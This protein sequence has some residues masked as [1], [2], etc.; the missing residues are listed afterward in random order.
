MITHERHHLKEPCPR[1]HDTGR[2]ECQCIIKG[3][4]G[5]FTCCNTGKLD[6]DCQGEFYC[7]DHDTDHKGECGP[8]LGEAADAARD[9]M[10]CRV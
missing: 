1:C 2:M 7:A 3:V 4:S 6:C 10:K 9:E 5:C 8:C